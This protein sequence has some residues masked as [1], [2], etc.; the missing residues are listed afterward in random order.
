MFSTLEKKFLADT[1]EQAIKILNHPEIDNNNIRFLLHIE[2]KKWWNFTDIHQNSRE[3][4]GAPNPWNE[5]AR[6]VLG[7]KDGDA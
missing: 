7:T 3:P 2:G 4:N 1:V 6:D 5:V